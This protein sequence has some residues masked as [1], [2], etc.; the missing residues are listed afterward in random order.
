[1]L[2]E[3]QLEA[4]DYLIV[5]DKT[6]EDIAKLCGTS[7]RNLYRWMKNEE[8]KA[9]WQKRADAYRSSLKKEVQN[10]MMN[11]V[12]MAMQNIWNLANKSDSDKIRLDANIFIYESQM[13]KAP[14]KIEQT[15][16]DKSNHDDKSKDLDDLLEEIQED[17]IVIPRPKTKGA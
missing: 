15:N 13:G 9:E 3:K 5:N 1:M 17:N 11:K 6:K 12:S 7:T 16:I 4:I 2:N 14:T 8:F 10:C